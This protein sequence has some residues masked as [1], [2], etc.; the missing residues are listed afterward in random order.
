VGVAQDQVGVVPGEALKINKQVHGF[1][2]KNLIR[3]KSIL[4]VI[5]I[6]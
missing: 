3:L 4:W 5:I 2:V 6:D 1:K